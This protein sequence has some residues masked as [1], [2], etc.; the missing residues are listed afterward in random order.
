MLG[1]RHLLKMI[2]VG[3]A[4]VLMIMFITGPS[5]QIAHE[6][7]ARGGIHS[8]GLCLDPKALK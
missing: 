8:R 6:C 4:I 7:E 5:R 3:G 1:M 2:L